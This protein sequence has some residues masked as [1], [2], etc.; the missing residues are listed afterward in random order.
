MNQI[1]DAMMVETSV[2]YVGTLN[3][4]A[5]KSSVQ[6]NFILHKELRKSKSPMSWEKKLKDTNTIYLYDDKKAVQ[7]QIYIII[8]GEVMDLTDSKDL[9]LTPEKLKKKSILTQNLRI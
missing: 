8:D 5:V 4:E 6:N 3:K 2:F 7:S 1:K 9:N